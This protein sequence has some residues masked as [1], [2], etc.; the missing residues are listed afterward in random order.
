MADIVFLIDGS[1]SIAPENFQQVQNFLRNVIRTL[2]I[3]ANKV[4]IGVA[5]YS[6]DPQTEFL[7][8]AHSDKKSLLAAVDK[9]IRKEGG[10]ETGKAI[11]FIRTQFF[12]HAAGSRV[13]QGVPQV[14]VVITDGESGDSVTK[15]AQKLRDSGV[16]VFAIGVG[17]AKKEELE[18][19]ANFKGEPFVVHVTDF[20]LLEPMR[21]KLL[22]TVCNSVEG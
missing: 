20:A 15:P 22:Q 9:I 4:R 7:L 21:E 6:N 2:D 13:L 1:T 17:E 3:G 14:A 10:T 5:Q 18:D 12:T 11:D 16:V 8:K 19:I